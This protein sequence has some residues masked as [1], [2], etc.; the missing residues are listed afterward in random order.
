MIRSSEP[1]FQP[2]VNPKS[3]KIVN[4][5]RK[6]TFLDRCQQ[7]QLRREQSTNRLTGQSV[8]P[9]CTFHPEL[10]SKGLRMRSRSIYELSRG[11]LH[12]KETNQRIIRL[13]TEQEELK[14]L[15]FQPA[16]VTQHS[17]QNQKIRS[18]L[19]LKDNPSGFIERYSIE[20]KQN[21]MVRQKIQE[22]R[23]LEELKECTFNPQTKECPNYIK[24]IAR[25][26]SVVKNMKG[27]ENQYENQKPDWK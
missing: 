7:D 15:T 8:D 18:T 22:Q 24:R 13:K 16:L 9:T 4:R 2:D 23:V 26:L 6:G 11:D 1:S 21:E 3:M 17:T 5:S 10:S 25:S 12:K 19:Q 27:N 20:Q 14:N